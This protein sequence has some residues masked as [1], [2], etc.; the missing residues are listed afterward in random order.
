MTFD[1]MPWVYQD[2]E[3]WATPSVTDDER[4][5][6]DPREDETDDLGDPEPWLCG[7]PDPDNA[8]LDRHSRESE[9]YHCGATWAPRPKGKR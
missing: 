6:W 2:G 3:R 5:K 8:D 9:P 1:P 4:P 7:S